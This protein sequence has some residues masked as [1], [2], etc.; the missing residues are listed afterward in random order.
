MATPT[1]D[2]DVIAAA[3]NWRLNGTP[4][5]P[6]VPVGAPTQPAV[7][8]EEIF[9]QNVF[10][11]ELM[12]QRLSKPVFRSLLATIHEGRPLDPSIADTVALAMKEW[13][14]E[15][16]GN[17]LCSLVPAVDRQHC[18]EARKFHYPECWGWRYRRIFRQGSH[19]RRARCFLLPQRWIAGDF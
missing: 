4:R 6:S 10:T 1:H 13:A 9:A 3:K 17:T 8:V 5:Q 16:G 14:L 12:Q 19:P 11:I 18:R 7:P 2:Y 15:R